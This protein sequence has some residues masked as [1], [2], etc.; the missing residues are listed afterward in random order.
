[1]WCYVDLAG[2]SQGSVCS[3]ACPELVV[4]NAESMPPLRGPVG[5]WS[6]CGGKH[7]GDVRAAPR[8]TCRCMVSCWLLLLLVWLVTF[9][10]SFACCG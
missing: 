3:L 2:C 9:T 10:G 5:A 8:C 4:L 7:V 1:M 6:L